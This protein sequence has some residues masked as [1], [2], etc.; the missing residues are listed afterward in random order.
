MGLTEGRGPRTLWNN[1]AQIIRAL[2]PDHPVMAFAPSVLR[3]TARRFL[4]G[5]PGLVTMP[6]RP[7]PTNP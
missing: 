7:T 3:D 1:P 4:D 5:F 2:A 6:S